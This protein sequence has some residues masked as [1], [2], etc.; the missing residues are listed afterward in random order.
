VRRPR[1]RAILEVAVWWGVLLSLWLLFVSGAT[2][3]EVAAGAVGAG[4]TTAIAV[5]A[6]RV[7]RV[8][9]APRPAWTLALRRL[10]LQVVRDTVLVCATLPGALAGRPPQGRFLTVAAATQGGGHLAETRRALLTNVV[11]LPPNTIAVGF[12]EDGNEMLV[13][14]LVDRPIELPALR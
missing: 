7:M 5:L 13:H 1:A 3:P 8:H 4:I 2:L 10:P 12:D 11:S 6:F 14:Q 9:F